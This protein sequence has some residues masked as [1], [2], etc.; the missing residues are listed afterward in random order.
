[1]KNT[2]DV[3]QVSSRK[4]TLIVVYEKLFTLHLEAT[5]EYLPNKERKV[6]FFNIHKQEGKN[7]VT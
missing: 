2:F 5:S 7:V 3:L 6:K 4:S 1:M